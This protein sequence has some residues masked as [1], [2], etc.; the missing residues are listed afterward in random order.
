MVVSFLIGVLRMYHLVLLRFKIKMTPVSK[1][2][3]TWLS[4][5]ITKKRKIELQ[6]YAKKFNIPLSHVVLLFCDMGEKMYEAEQETF[7]RSLTKKART[8]LK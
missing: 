7:E 3:G 4:I 6:R 8:C 2:D 5:R 1:K